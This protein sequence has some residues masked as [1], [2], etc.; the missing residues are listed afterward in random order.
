ML[1][2][3]DDSPSCISVLKMALHVILFISDVVDRARI[4]D[5]KYSGYANQI[6]VK[7]LECKT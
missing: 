5:A 3:R 1:A 6:A 2:I 4:V 7:M